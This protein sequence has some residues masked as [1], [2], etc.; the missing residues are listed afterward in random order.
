MYWKRKGGGHED[1][2]DGRICDRSRFV[3]RGTRKLGG[4]RESSVDKDAWVDDVCLVRPRRLP[5][6]GSEGF[7]QPVRGGDWHQ[8]DSRLPERQCEAHRDGQGAQRELGR[9]GYRRVLPASL[10]W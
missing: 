7:C 4:R 9:C 2:T 1:K 3:I 6:F 8:G 10:L 5:R